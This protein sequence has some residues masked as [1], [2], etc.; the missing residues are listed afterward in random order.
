MALS[1]VCPLSAV[2]TVH[3]AVEEQS[4]IFGLDCS[5]LNFKNSQ[6]FYCIIENSR[7]P[8]P[9][10]IM[11]TSTICYVILVKFEWTLGKI[12]NVVHRA[13]FTVKHSMSPETHL[14]TYP[15]TV[16]I[17]WHLTWMFLSGLV[18]FEW[19]FM[20]IEMLIDYAYFEK[21]RVTDFRIDHRLQWDKVLLQISGCAEEISAL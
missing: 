16:L 17:M 3:F 7:T 18:A 4:I 9:Q 13:V 2:I 6:Q 1:S 21:Y 15:N 19:R 11:I 14:L 12:K 8:P 5:N 20:D 10:N